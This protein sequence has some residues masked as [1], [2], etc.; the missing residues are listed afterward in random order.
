MHKLEEVR[1]RCAA[2]GAVAPTALLLENRSAVLIPT[3]P[4]T[5]K[6]EEVRCRCAAGGA[7]A[8]TALLPEN[9]PAVLIPAPRFSFPLDED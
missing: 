4:S 1:C 2:G 6:P 8:P 3:L 7:V 9:R 5:H